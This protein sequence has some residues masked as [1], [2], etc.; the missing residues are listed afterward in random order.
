MAEVKRERA[1]VTK[2]RDTAL[3][4][5]L[6]QAADGR[7]LPLAVGHLIGLLH[8]PGLQPT[9]AEARYVKILQAAIGVA[10]DGGEDEKDDED[11][12]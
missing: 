6:R 12:L 3:L 5:A 7:T 9:A 11:E 10:P 1:S 2:Q 4:L 8:D